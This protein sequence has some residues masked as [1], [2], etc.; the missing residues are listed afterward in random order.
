MSSRHFSYCS[1]C[2]SF[3]S[4]RQVFSASSIFIRSSSTFVFSLLALPTLSSE[5]DTPL[6]TQTQWPMHLS[7]LT[8]SPNPPLNLTST[9]TADSAKCTYT[10]SHNQSVCMQSLTT[11]LD[12]PIPTVF[13]IPKQRRGCSSMQNMHVNSAAYT[14]HII[15]FFLTYKST[16]NTFTENS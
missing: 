7:V 13:T 14:S 8:T 1:H 9:A 11:C 10:T 3:S 4:T 2:R 12:F 16:R 15:S 5:C 6:C